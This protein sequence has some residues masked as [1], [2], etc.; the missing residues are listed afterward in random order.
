M[1][2][3]GQAQDPG[4]PELE[5][6][7]TVVSVEDLL[8][9]IAAEEAPAE[10]ETEAATLEQDYMLVVCEYIPKIYNI[11]LFLLAGMIFAFTYVLLRN[12]ITRH[13]T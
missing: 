11:G 9:A 4:V 8:N 5:Q 12:I 1:P 7:V 10:E 6:P 3:E 2:E 13:F